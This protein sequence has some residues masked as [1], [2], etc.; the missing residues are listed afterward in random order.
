MYVLR[1]IDGNCENFILF[2]EP[3]VQYRMMLSTMQSLDFDVFTILIKSKTFL[4]E[5][6]LSQAHA[7]KIMVEIMCSSN[8]VAKNFE[9][10]CS[11]R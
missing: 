9:F 6:H 7:Y 2:P 11:G 1:S 10:Y 3:A 4:W 8:F 5:D